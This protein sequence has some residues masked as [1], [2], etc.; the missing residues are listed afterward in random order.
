MRLSDLAVILMILLKGF[1]LYFVI[2]SLFALKKP[3][4]YRQFPLQTR[5]AVV[6]PARNEEAVIAK[7][8]ETLSRM[9]Y[10]GEM[11]DVFVV[12]NNCTDNTRASAM[13]AGANIIDCTG[14]VSCKGDALNQSIGHL[15]KDGKR[16]DAFVIF[17]A[18]NQVDGQYLTHMNNA[19][20]SGARVAKGKCLCSNPYDSWVSGCYSIYFGLF[21]IFFNNARAN[22]GL[23][24]KLNG[25]G[26]AVRREVFEESGGWNTSTIAEDAEFSSQCA[27][28]GDRVYW[29][30]EAVSYDEQPLSFKASLL[31]RRRWCSGIMS[32][33]Q[34]NMGALVNQ[35]GKNKNPLTFDFIMFLM[36][37][38]A[39]AASLIPTVLLALNTLTMTTGQ[40]LA[41]LKAM[42]FTVFIYYLGTVALATV[43]ALITG[44]RDRGIVKA[45]LMY[46][47][48]MFSWLPLQILALFKKTTTWHQMAHGQTV[49]KHS[50]SLLRKP[51]DI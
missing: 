3:K 34:L 26:F 46:G 22:C 40:L 28:N 45:C 10:P 25:T 29:V 20:M 42:C 18:D 32:V 21:N 50:F 1:S 41:T 27:M 44:Q 35:F 51:S 38:F 6:I 9:D 37:L 30:P 5:F 43:I 14:P 23:S 36:G 19:L 8:V 47:V 16:Y 49:E 48:F 13:E 11:Y 33:A 12:P 31:Q 24:A 4:P 15:L 7:T 2:I 39:Q 17:D